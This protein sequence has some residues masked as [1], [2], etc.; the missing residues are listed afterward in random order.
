MGLTFWE[1]YPNL[2]HLRL[3]PLCVRCALLRPL[4]STDLDELRLT[5]TES[6]SIKRFAG[7]VVMK[8]GS[9]PYLQRKVLTN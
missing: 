8:L 6:G 4:V 5:N 1:T 3:T 7:L 2:T 9:V